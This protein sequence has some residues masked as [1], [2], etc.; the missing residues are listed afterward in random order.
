MGRL[1]LLHYMGVPGKVIKTPV[2]RR[3][4]YYEYGPEYVDKLPKIPN[5][6]SVVK[7][8]LSVT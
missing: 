2:R 4:M 1:E 8:G 7:D 6:R 3:K 5:T